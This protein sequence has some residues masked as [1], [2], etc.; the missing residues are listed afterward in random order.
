MLLSSC[1][2]RKMYSPSCSCTKT[3]CL[4]SSRKRGFS[5]CPR[6]LWEKMWWWQGER[7]MLENRFC[8]NLACRKS[9]V[10]SP[11]IKVDLCLRRLIGLKWCKGNLIHSSLEYSLEHRAVLNCDFCFICALS[12]ANMLNQCYPKFWNSRLPQLGCPVATEDQDFYLCNKQ[13]FKRHSL[14]W[15]EIR[16]AAVNISNGQLL[17]EEK[18]CSPPLIIWSLTEMQEKK[19]TMHP[20][21]LAVTHE[22]NAGNKFKTKGSNGVL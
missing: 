5:K 9:Q 1:P 16:E 15:L 22:K 17:E 10:W 19:Y 13:N 20:K 3:M 12:E 18:P 4:Q 7:T 14:P 21:R 8:T 11:A 2:G 6:T